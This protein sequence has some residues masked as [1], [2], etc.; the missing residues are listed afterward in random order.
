MKAGGTAFAFGTDGLAPEAFTDV[1]H[2]LVSASPDA[3]TADH[4][5]GAEL[6]SVLRTARETLVQSK[7]LQWVGYLSTTG[8]YGDH[9]GAWVTEESECRPGLARNQRRLEVEAAYKALSAEIEAPVHVFRL[10]GIYGP[11]RNKIA[12]VQD[13]TAQRILKEGHAFSRIHVDDIA[14][15]LMASVRA[16]QAQQAAAFDIFNVA[17]DEP[18]PSPSVIEELARLLDLPVPPVVAFDAAT[19]SPMARSFYAESKRTSNTKLK[20]T[21]GVKLRYPTY[22]EGL[23]SLVAAQSA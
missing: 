9:G 2:V 4:R 17:D 8:V 13:G 7:G 3:A 22:R 15:T 14:E 1:T 11:G 6:D 19:L 23:A 18:S 20:E 10:A 21:L 12:A 16:A 5:T